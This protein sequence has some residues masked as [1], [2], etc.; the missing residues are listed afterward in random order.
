MIAL[1]QLEDEGL[2]RAEEATGRRTYRLTDAGRAYVAGN[3]EALAE[4]WAAVAESISEEVVDLRVLFAQL[5][6]AMKQVPEA[7]TP[8]ST[9]GPGT[10]CPRP[11][12]NDISG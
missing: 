7:G 3:R 2:V 5:G 9:A 12:A 1:Q 6:V 8:A 4:P 11:G 10:S